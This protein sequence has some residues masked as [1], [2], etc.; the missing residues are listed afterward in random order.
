MQDTSIKTSVNVSLGHEDM[1][2]MMLQE[3]MEQKEARLNKLSTESGEV[4]DEYV[5]TKEELEKVLIDSNGIHSTK[6]YKTLMKGVKALDIDADA[7]ATVDFEKEKIGKLTLWPLDNYTNYANPM[8]QLRKKMREFESEGRLKGNTS[9][10]LKPST[11]DFIVDVPKCINVRLSASSEDGSV[12][13]NVKGGS[14]EQFKINAKAKKLIAKMQELMN[15][16]MKLA[17]EIYDL[18]MD[19]FALEHDTKRAKTRFIKGMLNNSDTGKELVGL[20]EGISG[21]NLIALGPKK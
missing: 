20:M 6:A 13:L 11:R 9:Y 10:H 5:A 12:H 8:A 3:A 19:L 21:Q 1:V 15:K 18:E 4:A 14:I 7:I 2:E 17:E 16:K